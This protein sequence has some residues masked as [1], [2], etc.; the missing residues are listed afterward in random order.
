[1]KRNLLFYFLSIALSVAVFSCSDDD[2]SFDDSSL[3]KEIT[4]FGEKVNTL[5]AD[6]LDKAIDLT[7]GLE[8]VTSLRT[9]LAT[10]EEKVLTSNLQDA[11]TLQN[12]LDGYS[13]KL[14]MAEMDLYK[15]RADEVKSILDDI[16]K[17]DVE[18]LGLMDRYNALLDEYTVLV[19]HINAA[20]YLDAQAVLDELEAEIKELAILAP[21]TW[22]GDLTLDD[23]DLFVSGSY[24]A[25]AGDIDFDG[26][27][28]GDDAPADLSSLNKLTY[29]AGS[30]Y[31]YDLYKI[32]DLAGLENLR[33]IGG[34]FTTGYC[35]ELASLNGLNNL[36]AI[37][38]GLSLGGDKLADISALASL[39]E[40]KHISISRTQ[41]SSLNVFTKVTALPD[42]LSLSQNELLT[43]L[44]GLENVTVC[45]NISLYENAMLKNIDALSQLTTMEGSISLI[46]NA[47]LESLAGLSALT[48]VGGF[49]IDGSPAITDLSGLTNLVNVN[50]SMTI[51]GNDAAN[52]MLNSLTGLSNLTSVTGTFTIANTNISNL[53]DLA[54]LTTSSW[55]TISANENLSDFCGLNKNMVEGLYGYHT[56]NNAYNPTKDDLIVGNCSN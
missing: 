7:N 25:V 2:E 41:I 40:V 48:E 16:N 36:T 46:K 45:K 20:C 42:G 54:N 27:G 13:G 53:D 24:G 17:D 3:L 32:T 12:T 21:P 56:S 30:I 8:T 19:E 10:L 38:E 31:L 50:G 52:K 22:K 34:G 43:S 35:D 44:D 29:V 28:M 49:T 18:S 33:E 11:L 9:E 4:A 51:G 37:G 47:E 23:I 26:Y 39:E 1:M 14:D 15:N 6:V 5:E 55:L